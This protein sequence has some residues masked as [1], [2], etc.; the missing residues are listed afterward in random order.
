[1]FPISPL[2]YPGGKA[3]L[4]PTIAAIMKSAGFGDEAVFVEPFAGGAGAGLTLLFQNSVKKLVLNDFDKAIAAFWTAILNETERFVDAIRT[5]PLDLDERERQARIY[6][7]RSTRLSFELGFAFFYLNRTSRA[8]IATAGPIGGW[9]QSGRW[10]LDDR[11]NRETASRRVLAIA[12]K[13]R[14][15]RVY[16]D[17]AT[18]FVERRLPKFRRDKTFVYFDPPYFRQ[19]ARLYRQ[20]FDEADH[21]RLRDAIFQNVTSPWLVSYDDAEEIRKIYDGASSTLIDVGYSAA[22]KRVERER[23]FFSPDLTT[24]LESIKE[25]KPAR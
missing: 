7:E 5:V 4:A 1:M 13:R 14:Q 3:R 2:R 18:S 9:S 21:R 25:K 11:F 16:C 6:A 8:G 19:G 23:L 12:E 15:I 10:K 20:A 17:D 24:V 22:K